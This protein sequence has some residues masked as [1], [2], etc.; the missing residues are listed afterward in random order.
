MLFLHIPQQL[1]TFAL[2]PDFDFGGVFFA[3]IFEVFP[4]ICPQC[5][6]PMRII[7][8]LDGISSIESSFA[9]DQI[10]YATALPL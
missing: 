2:G 5:G 9:L 8:F 4:L 6:G 10:K 7:A 1:T 3:R